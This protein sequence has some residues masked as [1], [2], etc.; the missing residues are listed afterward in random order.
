MDVNTPCYRPRLPMVSSHD[1]I[2][3]PSN[4]LEALAYKQDKWG[5][6][7]CDPENEFSMSVKTQTLR[8]EPSDDLVLRSILQQLA[9]TAE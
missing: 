7:Y 2:G 6:K 9:W 4:K 5:G 8:C 1:L 3:H